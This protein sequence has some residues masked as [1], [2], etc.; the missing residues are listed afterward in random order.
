MTFEDIKRTLHK[1]DLIKRPYII[2]LNPKDAEDLK[3]QMPEIE[4]SLV[5]QA[6]EFIEK[7]KGILMERKSLEQWELP[8]TD[9]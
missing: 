9:L 6:T 5:I 3:I 1:L 8:F 4:D 2:F 7:G